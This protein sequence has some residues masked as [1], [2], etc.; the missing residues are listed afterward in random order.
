MPRG[1]GKSG[2]AAALAVYG[3][4]ADGVPGAQ[5]LVVA[6]DERQARIV[7]NSARRMIELDE[8]LSEQVQVFTDRLYAPATRS[9][10]GTPPS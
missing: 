4:M 7:F 5:V 9:G 3:L 10:D 2:L 1:N 6:S 8:R